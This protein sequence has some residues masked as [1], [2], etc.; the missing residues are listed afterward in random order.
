MTG[1]RLTRRRL[2]GGLGAVGTGTGGLYVVPAREV[3]ASVTTYEHVLQVHPAGRERA[4]RPG[5]LEPPVREAVRAAIDGGYETHDPSTGLRSYLEDPR[6]TRYVETSDGYYRLD[7][8]LPVYVLWVE[9]VPASEAEDPVTLDE[10]EECIHPEDRMYVTPPT[11]PAGDPLRTYYLDENVRSCVRRHPY[12]EF[13]NGDVVEYHL[14]VEDPGPPYTVEAT[15]VSARAV[16]D[17]SEDASVVRWEDLGS[18]ERELLA[19]A[20]EKTLRRQSLPASVRGVARRYDHVHRDDEFLS[21][22]LDRPGTWPLSVEV[23]IPDAETREFD[24]AWLELSVGNEG[25]EPLQVQAQPP[26]PFGTLWGESPEGSPGG[27]LSLWS[28]SYA[29]NGD[30][31]V[32]AGDAVDR[33]LGL[34]VQRVRL[35]PGETLTRRYALRRNSGR[36]ETGTYGFTSGFELGRPADSEDENWAGDPVQYPVDLSVTVEKPD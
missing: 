23:R 35:S 8:T 26:V 18:A 14:A 7:A 5:A 27:D 19:D 9:R 21:V 17:V 24:P 22:D 36:L 12:V 34:V 29:E 16:A 2:L 28:R 10:L 1:L 25:P 33:S 3:S 32:F 20:E 31:A 13:E 30:A 15:P 11:P 4:D 6:E